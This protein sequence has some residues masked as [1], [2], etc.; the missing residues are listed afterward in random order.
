[1]A[2]DTVL[3]EIDRRGVATVTLNRPTVNNAY[4]GD[5]LQGLHDAMDALGREASLRVVVLRGNGKHFQAGADLAWINGV[6]AQSPAENERA[7]RVTAEAIRRLDTC[8]V[9]TLA[10]VQGGCF[11]GGTGVAAACDVVVASTD[12]L[13]SISETRWGLMAG[14]ILPQ[15]CQAIGLRQV[16]RYALT[17]ERFGAEEAR[18]IGLV[19]EVV[20][21]GGLAEAG[22]R[23]VDAILMNAPAATTATKLRSLASAQA[24]VDDGLLRDLIDEHARTR[25]QAE[26]KEGLAS[27]KEKRKP[28]WYPE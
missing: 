25:Q 27:F 2:N 4:N 13:F 22:A 28:A 24:F 18:R 5:L 16:R 8:P 21:V 11:G 20:P 26:A 9:P 17:G 12:A 1:M 6:A 10:L 23:I 7:S 19:H 15:L 14:I 3:W